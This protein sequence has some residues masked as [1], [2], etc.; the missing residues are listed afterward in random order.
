MEILVDHDHGDDGDD[1]NKED[2]FSIVQNPLVQHPLGRSELERDISF[3]APPR[4]WCVPSIK[5]SK[6]SKE[7]Q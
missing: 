3:C 1:E 5:A 4:L 7:S 6:Q 2:Y